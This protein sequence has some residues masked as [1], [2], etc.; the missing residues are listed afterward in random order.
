[1]QIGAGDA[2]ARLTGTPV[3][4]DFR[5]ADVAAGGQGAPLVPVFHRALAASLDRP[6]PLMVLNV[7]GVANVTWL[8][9]ETDD[10]IACDAGP[11][12]ALIDDFVHARSGAAFDNGGETAACGAVDEDLACAGASRSVLYEVAAEIASRPQ[13]LRGER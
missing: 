5:A 8:G 6:R 9:A 4:Y 12:N 2:L 3:A 1:M 7:G 10:P 13:C 11:G